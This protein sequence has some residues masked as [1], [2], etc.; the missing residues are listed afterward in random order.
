MEF[1]ERSLGD[2][3]SGLGGEG[4]DWEE[5]SLSEVS[6][7]WL[8]EG[9]APSV[10][11]RPGAGRGIGAEA[12]AGSTIGAGAGAGRGIGAGAVAVRVCGVVVTGEA[13]VGGLHQA[14]AICACAQRTKTNKF[15][16][17]WAKLNKYPCTQNSAN[18]AEL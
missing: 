4:V 2:G 12:G 5:G 7:M 15:S 10:G 14:V 9:R 11:R 8:G 17:I 3:G 18:F 1:R 6:S 13:G 16:R